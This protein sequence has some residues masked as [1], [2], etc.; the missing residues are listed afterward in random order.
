M[1][2]YGYTGG[3][4]IIFRTDRAMDLSMAER[5]VMI[6]L[7]SFAD[8]DGKCWPSLATLAKVSGGSI[9]TVRRS[10]KTLSN[11]KYITIKHRRG[12]KGDHTTNLYQINIE[13]KVPKNT[14]KVVSLNGYKTTEEKLFDRAWDIDIAEHQ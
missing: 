10:I 11:K 2:S 13:K 14:G 8:N 6:S 9:A 12:E 7:C 3:A 1:I 5:M 4:M